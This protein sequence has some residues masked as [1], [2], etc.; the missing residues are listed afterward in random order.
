MQGLKDIPGNQHGSSILGGTAGQP[1]KIGLSN[2]SFITPHLQ[3]NTGVAPP[4]LCR[5]V[6][7]NAQ[8]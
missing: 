6:Q 1:I 2:I 4:P 7:P 3:W 5:N 8:I